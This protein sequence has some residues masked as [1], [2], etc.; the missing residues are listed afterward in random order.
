MPVITEW[1]REGEDVSVSFQKTDEWAI[2]I[3]TVKNCIIVPTYN[4]RENIGGIIEKV[5]S[6]LPGISLFV[7]DDNSP[8]G[9]AEHVRELQKKYPQLM[10]LVRN[11]KSGLGSAYRDTFRQVLPDS[12]LE[13]II[14]MDG[15]GS[16]DPGY[17]PEMLELSNA[18]T[19]IIGSRYVTGGG[20]ENWELWRRI[21][22]RAGNK[23][24]RV[25]AGLPIH[26]CTAGFMCIPAAYLRRISIEQLHVSGYAFLI[27]LKY[28]L[29]Q[30][31]A[32]F[33]EIPIIFANRYRGASKISNHII[34]EGVI[35]PWLL[36]FKKIGSDMVRIVQ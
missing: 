9:T 23:Y 28:M 20:T 27:E 4:E 6:I 18:D 5:F 29:S 22:S 8:D 25:I 34:S 11:Q 32:S 19:V 16:H 24:S 30:A 21:L 36:R 31:G 1:H 2:L 7:V 26:D 35:T 17:I 10:L 15:D 3:S 12:E 33:K 13:R 14:I